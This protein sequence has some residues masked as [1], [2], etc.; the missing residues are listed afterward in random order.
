M[1]ESL[2]ALMLFLK[3]ICYNSP[4]VEKY[5]FNLLNNGKLSEVL[6][7]LKLLLLLPLLL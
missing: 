7:S 1:N 6:I 4:K 5:N 3:N 2:I